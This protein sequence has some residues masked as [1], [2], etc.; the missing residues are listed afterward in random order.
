MKP[1]RPYVA[2]LDQ[3]RIT[4]E[5]NDAAFIDYADPAIGGVHFTIGPEIADM[6]ELEILD[7]HNECLQAMQ[8]LADSY[9]HVAVEVPMGSPQIKYEERSDQWVPRGYVVRCV[10]S[11]GGPDG[12]AT[13]WVDDRELSLAEFGRMM[14]TYAGWGCRLVFVPDERV[15][16]RPEIAVREPEEK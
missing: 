1:K 6:T 12:E 2:S 13:F 14:T 10:I 15:H 11:D 8:D 7:L 16:E 4:R 3:V 5:R 9:Q